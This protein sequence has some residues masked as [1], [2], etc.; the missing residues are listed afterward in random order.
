MLA[1]GVA[2][3]SSGAEGQVTATGATLSSQTI[4]TVY[5][6][7][8]IQY[9]SFLPSFNLSLMDGHIVDAVVYSLPQTELDITMVTKFMDMQ[10]GGGCKL[11]TQ[12]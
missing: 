6:V 3:S 5:A 1:A 12:I 2:D 11:L 7:A 4:G 9:Y 8:L 10:E